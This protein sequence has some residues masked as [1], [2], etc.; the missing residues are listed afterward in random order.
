VGRGAFWLAELI[1]PRSYLPKAFDACC[2]ARD[3][4]CAD[5]FGNEYGGALAMLTLYRQ[6]FCPSFLF[7]RHDCLN[8]AQGV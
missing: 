4:A 5:A 7:W 2:V 6:G 8:G 3:S 1:E